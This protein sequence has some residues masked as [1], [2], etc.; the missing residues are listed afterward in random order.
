MF[1]VARSA[2]VM[3]KA[4]E[5][6]TL[7]NDVHRYPEFLPWC[8]GAE[9]LIHTEHEVIA[10]I[11]IAFK[12]INKTFTTRNQ[13][14]GNEKMILTLVNGP[15][16]T[17]SGVWEFTP[18]TTTASKIA[19]NLEFDFSSKIAASIIGPVFKTIA[20]SMIDSFCKRADEVYPQPEPNNK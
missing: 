14:I 20:D 11:T 19:L 16:S 15:F 7:V 10:T 3:H 1:I 4:E 6:F 5:M 2:L 18:L 12:G 13:L 9:E 8:G 17:L